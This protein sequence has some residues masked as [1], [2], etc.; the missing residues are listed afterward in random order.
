MGTPFGLMD[1]PTLFSKAPTPPSETNNVDV[2]PSAQWF[3]DDPHWP[4]SGF[5]DLKMRSGRQHSSPF[6]EY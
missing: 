4:E 2:A 1:S 6:E 5:K 3:S